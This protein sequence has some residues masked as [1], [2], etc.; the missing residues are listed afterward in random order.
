MGAPGRVGA[1]RT[2]ARLHLLRLVNAFRRYASPTTRASSRANAGP[3]RTVLLAVL[4]RALSRLA[5]APGTAALLLE[6]RRVRSG[7]LGSL[8]WLLRPRRSTAGP[9]HE[10][11]RTAKFRTRPMTSTPNPVRAADCHVQRLLSAV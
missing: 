10:G 9:F 1:A 8:N 6:V 2:G 3:A 4:R 5:P 11:H 7:R